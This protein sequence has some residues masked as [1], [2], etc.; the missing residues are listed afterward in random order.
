MLCLFKDELWSVYEVSVTDPG[1]LQPAGRPGLDCVDE[2]AE[3]PRVD[4]FFVAEEVVGH[5][6]HVRPSH[7][8][9]PL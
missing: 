7:F 9:Q 5:S 2:V 1:P 6:V 3:E 8:D 4:G